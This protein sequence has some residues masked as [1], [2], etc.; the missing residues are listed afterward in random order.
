MLLLID[1]GNT[2]IK[3]VLV[4]ESLTPQWGV[5]VK[6]GALSHHDFFQQELPWREWNVQ[7]I[8]ISNVAGPAVRERSASVFPLHMTHWFMS[9]ACSAGIQN[10]YREPSQLGSDRFATSIAAHTLFPGK[11]L[12]VAT[13]GTATTI[14]AI[15]AEGDFI[16]GMIV[17]G[18]KLMTQSLAQ[19]TAQL[20]SVLASGIIGSPF[21]D[22]TEAAIIS[23]CLAAQAGAI[24]RAL[25]SFA[26]QSV[27]AN[28]PLCILS[29]GAAKYIA[30]SLV[31][32]YQIVDN[33]VLIGLQVF[34]CQ[35]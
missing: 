5:W 19:N 24:E 3:W 4:A 8:L 33:L 31:V 32:P 2:Q 1:A 10:H 11:N 29:G 9:Q 28:A 27:P 26:Q 22:H 25:H 13:C 34:S 20:P 21:A 23:G 18:L 7:R 30:P 17:P 15:S 12:L 6:S 14:D 35:N 16:G